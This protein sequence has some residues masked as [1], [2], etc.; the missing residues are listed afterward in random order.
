ME[1]KVEQQEQDKRDGRT[2]HGENIRL[3]KYIKELEKEIE[4]LKKFIG[5]NLWIQ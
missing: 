4:Q 5:G 1:Q 2:V 3:K